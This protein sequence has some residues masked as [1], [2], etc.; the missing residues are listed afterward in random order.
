MEKS[1]IGYQR[2]TATKWAN[3]LEISQFWPAN[4]KL[5]LGEVCDGG[6]LPRMRKEGLIS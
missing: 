5:G 6:N 3:Y 1:R 4:K 2:V